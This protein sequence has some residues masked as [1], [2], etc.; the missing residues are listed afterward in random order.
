MRELLSNVAAKICAI[1]LFAV[2]VG[3]GFFA[4]IGIDVVFNAS[5]YSTDSNGY[6]L[7]QMLHPYEELFVPLLIICIIIALS[8][9]IF[10]LCASGRRK[11]VENFTPNFLD[12]VPFDLY[13]AI[14]IVLFLLSIILFDNVLFFDVA[15]SLPLCVLIVAVMGLLVL[16]FLMTC[17]TRFKIGK[18]W[19]NSIIY[20]WLAKPIAKFLSWLGRQLKEIFNNINLL[21]KGILLYCAFILLSIIFF[22][23]SIS[24]AGLASLLLVVLGIASFLFVCTLMLQMTKLKQGAAKMAAGDLDYRVDTRNMFHDLK[25]HGKDLNRISEGMALAVEE[26]MKSEHFKTELITNVS[27]DLK[28]PLTSIINYVDLLQK[29]EIDNPK[30]QEYLEVLARQSAR[31]K[32][33]TEDLV[34]ASKASTGNIQMDLTRTDMTEF[35]NQIMGEYQE[36]FRTVHLESVVT[37]PEERVYILADGR[38][39][40][41]VFDNLLNNICKYSQPNTRVFIAMT[42]SNDKVLISL[43]NTSRDLLNIPAE[44]LLERFV[45]A[46]SSRNS[47]GSGLGL[48][49]ARSLT[50]LQKGTL[51]LFVDGDLF[52]VILTFD[53]INN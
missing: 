9:L 20:M 17:S 51:E 1:V 30:A 29:E 15:I 44:D 11:D 33:L 47:E 32:K 37:V 23:N 28:T 25:E 6:Y 13:L 50:E 14:D 21:W 10:L 36:R 31:L 7:Y 40:W 34:E 3:A 38:S 12:R 43:K 39:L 18:W 16:A 46:D 5:Y 45:R 2:A 24:G 26:R 27:H 49:I 48:S 19:R 8:T 53:R 22:F 35:I 4:L 41:R 52:K 42:A